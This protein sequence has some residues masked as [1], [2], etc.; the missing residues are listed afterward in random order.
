[1]FHYIQHLDMFWYLIN[2]VFQSNSKQYVCKKCTRWTIDRTNSIG[3]EEG[4]AI[5]DI[6]VHF[7]GILDT[8]KSS[9]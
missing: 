1:M 8:E 3:S 7:Q 5:H 9:S 4:Y 2:S 6:E